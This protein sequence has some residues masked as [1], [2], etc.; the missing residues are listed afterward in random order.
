MRQYKAGKKPI[1][2]VYYKKSKAK[3]LRD[4]PIQK[5]YQNELFTLFISRL[6]KVHAERDI[7]DADKEKLRKLLECIFE[8]KDAQSSKALKGEI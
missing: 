4:E 7:A 5:K 3:V 1:V 2:S 6:M 8:E